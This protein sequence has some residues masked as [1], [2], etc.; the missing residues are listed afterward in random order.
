MSVFFVGQININ[1]SEKY[2]EYLRRYDAVFDRY[3][4]TVVAVDDSVSVLEGKWPFERTVIIE[5]PSE[6][7]LRNWYESTDYQAIAEFRREA[8]QANIVLVT[9]R[10]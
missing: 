9:G 6:Q 3:K 8:S 10:E 4:G 1:D 2:A 7:D 5:F